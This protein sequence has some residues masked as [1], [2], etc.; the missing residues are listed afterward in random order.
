MYSQINSLGAS[1]FIGAQRDIMVCHTGEKEIQYKQFDVFPMCR[2]EA[3]RIL[4][5]AN[6][7]LAYKDAILSLK[8]QTSDL[9]H[10]LEY[11]LSEIESTIKDD[12]GILVVNNPIGA[13]KDLIY[14]LAQKYKALDR[15]L[16]SFENWVDEVESASYHVSFSM[17]Q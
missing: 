13:Y 12:T 6:P 5:C 11:Q 17:V 8:K 2:E 4:G 1:L 15:H 9:A 10:Y 14:A 7:S 3:K 16:T